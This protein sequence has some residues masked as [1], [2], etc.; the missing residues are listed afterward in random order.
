MTI[1]V[2]ENI[3]G[4]GAADSALDKTSKAAAGVTQMFGAEKALPS[5]VDPTNLVGASSGTQ[6]KGSGA[7]SRSGTLSAT[8]TARVME[9]LP[10]GDLVLEGAREIEI[11][12]DR[13]MVVL[14][15]VA[16]P[17]DVSDQ[18]V[19]LSP[20]IGQL[21][22][23]Y[24]G[25]GLMK[26]N[27]KPGLAGPRAQQ[28]V[29]MMRVLHGLLRLVTVVAAVAAFGV[30]LADPAAG[31]TTVRLRDVASLQG[32]APVPLIGYGLVVGLNKSG[33]R[34]QT[35]FSAQ[36]LANMLERFGVLVPGEDIKIENVAAVLVT[37]E[38][39]A[40]SRR[41]SRLDVTASSIGDARSLQGGTLLPTPLRGTD[42]TIYVL[43][44]GPLSLGGFGGGKGGNSVQVNHLTVGRVPAGGIIQAELAST[45]PVAAPNIL[46]TLSTPD[47][48]NATRVADAIN[49]EMG[50]GAA[51]ALDAASVQVSVPANYRGALPNLMARLE[52]LPVSMGGP[53]RIVINERT[54]TVVVGNE[55]RL[56]APRSRTAISR[57]G[58]APSTTCRSRTRSRRPAR[59]RWSC[60]TRRSTSPRPT[61]S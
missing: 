58:S 47:F 6:F 27:L 51:L 25:R 29:L 16:R 52:P 59:R 2:V 12:G 7:T 48:T 55:V 49:A 26:D 13:Q 40:F 31:D 61:P 14:T 45:V 3:E 43:A 50:P 37:A 5:A 34:R 54:G 28:G 57:C 35:M 44:Q 41:G 36:T 32:A 21:R 1:R 20:K 9:V 60:R 39:P 19:V 17:R 22:I 10:N 33:D 56:A 38:L 15:G 23:R 53:A 18:N 11:N 30:T 42:G 4:A 8:I 24:F 46:L